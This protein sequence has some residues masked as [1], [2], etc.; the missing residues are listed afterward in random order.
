MPNMEKMSALLVQVR[1]VIDRLARERKV[2]ARA[3]GST[4]DLFPIAVDAAEGEELK[5]WIIKEKAVRTI[6]IGLAYGVSAPYICEGLLANGDPQARHVATDPFQGSYKNLGLQVLEEA[7]GQRFGGSLCRRV[8][9]RAAAIRE[10]GT[11]IRS[12]VRRRQ[13]SF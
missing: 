1:G 4:H 7:G 3:D 5:A 10:R 11:T 9:D 8:A 12:R 6:E 13:P 2:V